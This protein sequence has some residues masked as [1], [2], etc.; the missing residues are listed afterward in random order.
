MA[1]EKGV[2]HPSRLVGAVL[3]P[4]SHIH[5]RSPF[6][7][8]RARP[9]DWSRER[10]SVGCVSSPC[11]SCFGSACRGLAALRAFPSHIHA[12]PPTRTAPIEPPFSTCA[13]ANLLTST[14][15]HQ[16]THAQN[17]HTLLRA[18]SF[19]QLSRC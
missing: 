4:P 10:C 19:S 9:P 18:H 6:A 2:F 16:A 1:V 15:A 12:H 3:F 17:P 5:A 13:A 14:H 11:K 8:P 7:R